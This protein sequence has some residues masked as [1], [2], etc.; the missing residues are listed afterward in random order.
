ME[1][2]TNI[3]VWETFTGANLIKQFYLPTTNLDFLKTKFL[4]GL[5]HGPEIM[6][7]DFTN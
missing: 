5:A 6:R 4:I 1:K 2:Q 7:M 3:I